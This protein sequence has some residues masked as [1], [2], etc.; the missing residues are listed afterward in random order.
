[1]KFIYQSSSNSILVTETR[2]LSNSY[3]IHRLDICETQKQKVNKFSMVLSVEAVELQTSL[4]NHVAWHCGWVP[5]PPPCF[6]PVILPT[7]SVF[8]PNFLH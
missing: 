3:L 6:S 4:A 1:M 5:A 8:S 7:V 2:K